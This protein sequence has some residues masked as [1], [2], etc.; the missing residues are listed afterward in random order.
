[1]TCFALAPSRDL[2]RPK[3]WEEDELDGRGSA[4]R[5]CSGRYIAPPVNYNGNFAET[6]QP[7]T[8]LL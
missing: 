8:T 7:L 2:D 6:D 5:G 3:P 1:M 4:F